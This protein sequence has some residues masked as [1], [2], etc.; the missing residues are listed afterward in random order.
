MRD[1]ARGIVGTPESET[2]ERER[3]RAVIAR[4]GSSAGATSTA[5]GLADLDADASVLLYNLAALY[6]QEKQYGAAKAV[7]EHLFLHIEPL[8]EP[9]AIHICFLLLDVLCHSARGNLHTEASL[10][11]FGRETA[12]VVAFLERPHALNSSGESGGGGGGDAKQDDSAGSSA[13]CGSAEQTEFSFRLHLY[14]AKLLLLQ[15]QVFDDV[16]SSPPSSPSHTH[17]PPMSVQECFLP[18]ST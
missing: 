15:L 18:M 1:K 2:E 16:S 13:V 8:D 10:R 6:F 12:T 9:L 17:V 7:L 5:V 14:K 3:R 4:M 11:R